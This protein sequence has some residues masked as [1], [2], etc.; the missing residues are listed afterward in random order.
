M[1][2]V[3]AIARHHGRQAE[4]CWRCGDRAFLVRAHLVDRVYG[5]SDAPDNLALLCDWCHDRMPPFTDHD[6]ATAYAVPPDPSHNKRG[7]WV[8][9]MVGD[10]V[11]QRFLNAN[12]EDGIDEAEATDRVV[13]LIGRLL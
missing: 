7:E 10:D 9:G 11:W 3:G 12:R 4:T 6:E 8:R 2:T 13:D 1:P 5:G